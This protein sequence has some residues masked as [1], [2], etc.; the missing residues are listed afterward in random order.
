MYCGLSS[1]SLNIDTMKNSI[2]IASLLVSVTALLIAAWA[3]HEA[4]NVHQLST[5]TQ[6]R[7]AVLQYETQ[8]GKQAVSLKCW[9][10]FA[11]TDKEVTAKALRFTD[12]LKNRFQRS[13]S[14]EKFFDTL[15][16]ES[17]VKASVRF[18][19]ELR[20]AVIA[21]HEELALLKAQ[22][23]EQNRGL[24]SYVCSEYAG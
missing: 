8:L 13:I 20:E 22:V 7:T 9:A 14:F 6:F 17:N 18:V 16:P 11:H 10:E 5:A 24:A 23:A 15:E 1:L 19:S 2:E 3:V 4:R 12:D 21:Y